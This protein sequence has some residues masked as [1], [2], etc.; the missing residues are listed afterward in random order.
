MYQQPAY[1]YHPQAAASNGQYQQYYGGGA[2]N[3]YYGYQQ[4]SG[5]GPQYSTGGSYPYDHSGYPRTQTSA[6]D[7]PADPHQSYYQ[8]QH[9]YGHSG[10]QQ[11]G[12]GYTQESAAYGR[13]AYPTTQETGYNQQLASYGQAAAAAHQQQQPPQQ[14]HHYGGGAGVAGN[15]GH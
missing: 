12:T 8:T 13:S 6:G 1:P 7:R 15:Y 14:T 10:A 5:Y 3:Q 9:T 2:S 4:Q 11:M